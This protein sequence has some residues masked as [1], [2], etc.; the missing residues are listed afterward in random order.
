[1][2]YFVWVLCSNLRFVWLMWTHVL[3]NGNYT[4]SEHIFR[5]A[6]RCIIEGCHQLIDRCVHFIDYRYWDMNTTPTRLIAVLVLLTS[7]HLCYQIFAS[8]STD[9][10]TYLECPIADHVTSDATM[11]VENQRLMKQRNDLSAK[12][13]NLQ[14]QLVNWSLHFVDGLRYWVLTIGPT[15]FFIF[16]GLYFYWLGLRRRDACSL[17]AHASQVIVCGLI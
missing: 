1:V 2:W 4:I 16:L 6:A 10:V 12:L 8:R 15:C 17:H 3:L 7:F 13:N 11:R 9:H 5:R 14:V